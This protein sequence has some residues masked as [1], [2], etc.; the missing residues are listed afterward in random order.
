MVHFLQFSIKGVTM[1]TAFLHHKKKAY[2][3]NSRLY[4]SCIFDLLLKIKKRCFTLFF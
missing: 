3:S 2:G 4:I 1:F